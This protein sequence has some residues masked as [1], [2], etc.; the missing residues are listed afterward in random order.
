MIN[1]KTFTATVYSTLRAEIAP[2]GLSTINVQN[3]A[4]LA[5]VLEVAVRQ[6]HFNQPVTLIDAG[7]LSG[8]FAEVV[9]VHPLRAVD[10]EYQ[11]GTGNVVLSNFRYYTGTMVSVR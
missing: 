10:I 5:G 1:C 9:P 2:Q 7:S 3:Q 6:K 11:T 4:A 8:Q